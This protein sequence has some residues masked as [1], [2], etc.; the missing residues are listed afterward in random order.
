M[1]VSVSPAQLAEKPVLWRL[2]QLYHY[3][4]TEFLTLKI[5]ED[6]EYAYRYLDVY[7]EPEP[8]ENRFPFLIR[9]DGELAGFA[10]V[11]HVNDTFLMSEFF[12]MRPYRR[13]GVGREAA[14]D[15]FRRFPGRWIV[16]QVPKNL[17]AQAFWRRVIGE[18]TRGRFE[19]STD[20]RGVTQRFLVEA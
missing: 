18:L 16:H 4:F 8:D 9:V 12:V 13:G 1:T 17:P 5:G 3:D 10:L 2:L 11:R 7:W 19:D 20:D 14:L 15:V 6:G